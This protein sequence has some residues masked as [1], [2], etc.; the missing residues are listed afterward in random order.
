MTAQ[1][2]GGGM[3]MDHGAMMNRGS[4]DHGMM[5]MHCGATTPCRLAGQAPTQ[6]A[7]KTHHEVARVHNPH[8]HMDT[9]C[10][11]AATPAGGSA[12]RGGV[13][14]Q[15]LR[16]AGIPMLRSIWSHCAIICRPSPDI[17]MPDRVP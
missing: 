13:R 4:M 15:R 6:T 10:H 11:E 1:A 17:A 12:S 7:R 5:Q 14:V 9:L 16:G 2:S 3:G 8:G